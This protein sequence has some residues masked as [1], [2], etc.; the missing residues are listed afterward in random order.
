[1]NDMEYA[2]P[3]PVVVVSGTSSG[4]GLATALATARAGWTTVA[5]MRDL[6]RAQRLRTAADSAGLALDIR[7]LDVTDP[8]SINECLDSVIADHRRLD[9]VVNNAGS[10]IRRH[11]RERRHRR[12][13]WLS[14][15]GPDASGRKPVRTCAGALYRPH[16]RA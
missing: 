8:A 10:A 15:P 9:A 12:R 2:R 16:H 5:T 7:R 13:T 11:D 4:I 6:G 1:M 14:R 3:A